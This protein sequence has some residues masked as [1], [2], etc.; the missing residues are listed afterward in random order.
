MTEVGDGFGSAFGRHHPRSSPARLPDVGDGEKLLAERVLVHER[1]AAVKMLRACQRILSRALP[2]PAP[3]GRRVS[4]GSR[5]AR[6]RPA[7]ETSRAAARP[8]AFA[9]SQ[10]WPAGFERGHGHPV[11]RER[12]RL[13]HAQHRGRPERLD[14][15]RAPREDVPPREAP[16]AQGEEDREDHRKLLGHERHREGEPGEEAFEPPAPEES[17]GEREEGAQSEPRGGED[18]HPPRRLRLKRRCVRIERLQR[19]ADSPQFGL[20]A[21]GAHAGDAL[22][23]HDERAGPDVRQ[24]VA[25]R[26]SGLRRALV[27]ALRHR[28]R[29]SG[30][31]GLVRREAHRLEEHAVGRHAVALREDDEVARHHLAAGDPALVPIAHDER[32][33]AREIAQ[34]VQSALRLARLVQG[35]PHDP[36]DGCEEDE[37]FLAVAQENIDPAA[38]EKEQDHRLFQDLGG[39]SR[40]TPAPRGRQLVRA[41]GGETRHGLGLGE[42]PEAPRVGIDRHRAILAAIRAGTDDA[43]APGRPGAVL[44]CLV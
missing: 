35:K 6:T 14:G 21:R 41:L 3:S 33:R 8:G 12:P 42:P 32:A 25:S 4:A 1:P 31:K 29:L 2:R 43:P 39:E 10:V 16:R 40:E 23:P 15:R 19:L 37:S 9:T 24:P 28:D 7:G 26:P 38:R 11:L 22:P 27:R 30:E 5:G 36:E 20:R 13:V 34:S 17:E 18:A 44:A